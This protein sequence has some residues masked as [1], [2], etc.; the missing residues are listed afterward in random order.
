[1]VGGLGKARE[2]LGPQSHRPWR[3]QHRPQRRRQLPGLHFD[4]PHTRSRVDQTSAHYF[5]VGQK[6]FLRPDS[7]VHRRSKGSDSLLE[8]QQR[9]RELRFREPLPKPR[10]NGDLLAYFGPL[11]SVGR[12]RDGR[13]L[14]MV[15]EGTPHAVETY[16]PDVRREG[17]AL[18]LSGGGYRAALF[19]L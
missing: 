3:L 10:R 9:G 2:V 18:A 19:H 11:S 8:V 12:V 14:D 7:L 5:Q 1:M 16:A 4:G 17:L 15:V 13:R 6:Q